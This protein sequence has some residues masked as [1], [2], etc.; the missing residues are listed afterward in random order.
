M[1]EDPASNEGNPRKIMILNNVMQIIVFGVN[2]Y[3]IITH[4]ILSATPTR[5]L[6][7]HTEYEK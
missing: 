7:L 6:K 3:Y 1:K 4:P 2:I 5:I